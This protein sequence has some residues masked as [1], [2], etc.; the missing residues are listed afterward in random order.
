MTKF[1]QSPNLY[2]L[3][4]KKKPDRTNATFYLTH[5]ANED[6]WGILNNILVS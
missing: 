6:D 5:L 1:Y 4:L 2:M 3:F